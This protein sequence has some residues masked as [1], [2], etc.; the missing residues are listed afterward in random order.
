M[1]YSDVV[2]TT[3]S[4]EISNAV[5]VS[6]TTTVED[7]ANSKLR[8]TVNAETENA[9]LVTK[10]GV[11]FYRG[12][13]CPEEL[14]KE[15]ALSNADILDFS[16]EGTTFTGTVKDSKGGVHYVGYAVLADGTVKYSDVVSTKISDFLN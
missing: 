10:T 3:I 8:L 9:S 15:S 13:E 12:T 7:A 11:I 5:E 16:L 6:P 14:T 1:K 4:E 2:S